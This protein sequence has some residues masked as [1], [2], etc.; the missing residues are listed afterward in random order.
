VI[1]EL[2]GDAGKARGALGW[3]PNLGFE[4]VVEIM[5]E[6]DLMRLTQGPTDG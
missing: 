4:Q 3:S 6:G 1:N 2:R 5:V